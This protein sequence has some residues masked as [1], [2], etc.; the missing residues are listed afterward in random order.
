MPRDSSVNINIIIIFV[1]RPTYL[2][3]YTFP[4]YNNIA[5]QQGAYCEFG[6]NSDI[7]NGYIIIMRVTCVQLLIL[8]STDPIR[9]TTLRRSR[10]NRCD[11][12]RTVPWT[13]CALRSGCGS[14]SSWR[15]N[16]DWCRAT[17]CSLPRPST[18]LSCRRTPR[19]G[20]RTFRAR[21]WS[22]CG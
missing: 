18:D 10:W 12:R 2:P 20:S 8:L 14:C 7:R 15:I 21:P 6:C 3:A 4:I 19:T 13:C 11:S 17:P 22:P 9:K 1:I 5:P 16:G